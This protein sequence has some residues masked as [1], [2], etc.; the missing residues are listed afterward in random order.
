MCRALTGT[1]LLKGKGERLPSWEAGGMHS[2]VTPSLYKTEG[3]RL[4]LGPPFPPYLPFIL[5]RLP[6]SLA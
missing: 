6:P 3:V 1:R 4:A 2:F 5:R